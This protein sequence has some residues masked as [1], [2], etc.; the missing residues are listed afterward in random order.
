LTFRASEQPGSS[1]IYHCQIMV[2]SKIVQRWSRVIVAV[3]AASS[4]QAIDISFA[5]P[6]SAAQEDLTASIEAPGVWAPPASFTD[7]ITETFDSRTTLAAGTSLAI[8][9]IQDMANQTISAQSG[10]TIASPTWQDYSVANSTRSLADASV[11][12]GAGGTGKFMT[13]GST[14]PNVSIGGATFNLANISGV[15]PADNTYRYLG[16]WWSAGNSPNIVRL[17]ND[18][19]L[20]ATF[21]TASLIA[22]LGT[23][24]SLVSNDY[25]G[26]PNTQF[27]SDDSPCPSGNTCVGGGENE[28]YA[29]IHLR[30]STGFDQIQFAGHGFE[31]DSLSI[32]R[33]VPPSSSGE[34][35]IVGSGVVSSC[36]SFSNEN[37]QY[38]LQ[39]GSFEDDY[40]SNASGTTT[41]S[42]S[43]VGTSNDGNSIASWLRYQGGPYQVMNLYDDDSGNANRIRFWKT[44]ATDNKVELQRQVSGSE[45]SATRNG[46]DYFDLYGPRPAD[47][48]VHAE[49][50]ATQ[51]AA[52]YQDIV[53][54]GGEKVTWSIKHRG[55]YFGAGAT[56]QAASSDSDD[57][58]KF[59]ILIGPASGTLASQ[60]PSRKRLPD[61]VWNT[62][63]ATYVNNAATTF[64][65]NATGHTTGT[66]YT[67]LQDGWVL[68]TGTYTVPAGQTTTRFSFSS[69]GTGTVGN[70]ID[71]IGFDPIIACPRTVTI[72]RNVTATYPVSPLLE[73]QIP[74]YSYPNTTSVTSVSINGGDGEA[75][76]DSASGQ[77][78]L[79]SNTVGSF[80]VLYTITD[81]NNQTSTSTITVNV[82][83]VST[84]LPD[85][86][87]IDP[88]TTSISLPDQTL[89]GATNAMV[90]V[91]Q[92]ANAAAGTLSGSP[93]IVAG[94]STIVANVSLTTSTN[95]WRFTGARAD[96]QTQVP[97]I[98]ISGTGNDPLVSS[99]SKFVRVGVSAAPA[100]GSVACFTGQSRVV[101][102]RSVNLQGSVIKGV[103]F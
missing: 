30:L 37:A 39:N 27:N 19:V 84:Q 80:Q 77:I 16:F 78:S 43:N 38:V 32:R 72:Q 34:T 61:S 35:S 44:T 14:N 2:Q 68:Y 89:A 24:V 8:G 53:T 9:T 54:I 4:I 42:L 62:G 90:C 12:G 55:R 49:I 99:G 91:Q 67:R 6:A 59:E 79:S 88:R 47:G 13:L 46:T 102:L 63:N 85:V 96:V 97:S 81:I 5:P 40:L 33:F 23:P 94:R 11:W 95:L 20:Q 64:A 48:S 36:S 45:A 22:Q 86:L 52:L 74:G 87:L 58:D 18:G 29:Y 71:D 69:R 103:T 3:L 17:L 56:S 70:L 75:T 98:T 82:E 57:R 93:T 73:S 25:F 66:M 92:V 21:T 76:L 15:S 26:N 31:F 41:A 1:L 28:P 50:N 83:D 100:M 65:T 7:L 10:G 101:E 60:T 51:K